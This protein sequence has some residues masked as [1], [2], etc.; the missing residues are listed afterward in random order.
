MWKQNRIATIIRWTARISGSLVLAFLLFFLLAHVFGND[1]SG[2]G[3]RNSREVIS[4][5]FFPISTVIGLAV[6]LKWE[7]LGGIIILT[8]LVGIFILVP[9]LRTNIYMIAP[10]IPGLLFIIF[11]LLTKGQ[12]DKEVE[13]Y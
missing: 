7:G 8:G 4:F 6:A 11:W 2:E 12:R 10:I 1:E 13:R 9:D 3:F 5:I